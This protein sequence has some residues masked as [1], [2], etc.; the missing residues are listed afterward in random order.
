MT[1]YVF[2]YVSGRPNMQCQTKD[3][4][5]FMNCLDHA[6]AHRYHKF[7]NCLSE[8]IIKKK[9]YTLYRVRERLSDIEILIKKSLHAYRHITYERLGLYV[10]SI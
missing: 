7:A 3:A 2:L 1:S 6:L 9:P 10:V 8:L 4:S 5:S